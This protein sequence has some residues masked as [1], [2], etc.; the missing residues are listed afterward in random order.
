M[1]A[2]DFICIDTNIFDGVKYNF[3]SKSIEALV[4]AVRK[5]PKTLLLPLPLKQEVNRHIREEAKAAINAVSSLIKY[6]MLA[7]QMSGFP[8]DKSEKKQLIKELESRVSD[9]WSDFLSNFKVVEL[10]CSGIDLNQV[11][12]WYDNI[13]PPFGESEK[14]RKEFPDA[15]ALMSLL[16]YAESKKVN[17]AVVSN[18][19]DF[20]RFCQGENH[21]RLNYYPSLT[22]LIAEIVKDI[23]KEE[24]IQSATSFA[25]R[26]IP[27]LID[28][29]K[30]EFPDRMF[31][32]DFAPFDDSDNVENVC[33]ESCRVD[34]EQ[35]SIIEVW[36]EGF[37]VSYEAEIEYS[38]DVEYDDPNSWVNMGDGDIMYM[39]RCSGS[40]SNTTKVTGTFEVEMDEIWSEVLGVSSVRIEED[41]IHISDKTDQ[42]YY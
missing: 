5:K 15:F 17:I 16:N 39:E 35:M 25:C 42:D 34:P 4:H 2:P 37:L 31:I 8:K 13:D 19:G 26:S 18:D 6:H 3:S 38:A 9:N 27:R 28:E 23:E 14:K 22:E 20:A 24:R 30:S 36:D 29:L 40:I 41:C 10:D 33:V 1:P 11:M 32:V 21:G 7:G 12:L